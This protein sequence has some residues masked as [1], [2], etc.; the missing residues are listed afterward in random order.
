MTTL[1]V[2]E[3][4]RFA[5]AI[6]DALRRSGDSVDLLAPTDLLHV[7]RF[8]AHEVVIA[9]ITGRSVRAG[10]LLAALRQCDPCARLVVVGRRFAIVQRI[11]AQAQGAEAFISSPC[12]IRDVLDAVA[13]N[14]PPQVP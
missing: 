12:A 7:A 2:S 10:A 6:A 1:V 11:L 8:A 13:S 5:L 14:A 9:D 4:A 3:D